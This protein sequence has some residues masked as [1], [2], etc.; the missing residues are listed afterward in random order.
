VWLSIDS[1]VPD[2]AFRRRFPT[3][4]GAFSDLKAIHGHYYGVGCPFDEM[5]EQFDQQV[6]A[7]VTRRPDGR[8]D[9][10]DGGRRWLALKQRSGDQFLLCVVVDPD[11]NALALL[12]NDRHNVMPYRVSA[13]AR[14]LARMRPVYDALPDASKWGGRRAKKTKMQT[15]DGTWSERSSRETPRLLQVG[16]DASRVQAK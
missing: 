4:K 8:H 15:L 1:I 14:W 5:P 2:E 6:P 9:L 12:I 13:E 10:H 3:Y 11:P 16:R 7:V